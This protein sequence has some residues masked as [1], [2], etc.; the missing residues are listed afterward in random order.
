MLKNNKVISVVSIIAYLSLFPILYDLFAGLAGAFAIIPVILVAISFG[1]KGGIIIGILV[2]PINT[3]LFNLVGLS[4]LNVVAKESGMLPTLSTA[5]IGGIIGYISELKQDLENELNKKKAIGKKL[6]TSEKQFR[7]TINSMEDILITFDHDLVCTSLFVPEK[8]KDYFKEEEFI[9]NHI[10]KIAIIKQLFKEKE[11]LS[12]KKKIMKSLEGEKNYQELHLKTKDFEI[13]FHSSFTPLK[14]GNKII[15]VVSVWRD[16]TR[17]KKLQKKLEERA[18]R[19]TMLDVLN[20]HTGLEYLKEQVSLV[21]KFD[22][23]LTIAFIDIDNLKKTNDN[24]GHKEGDKL[25]KIV[26]QTLK[27]NIRSQETIVRFGGDEFLVI[28]PKT[29]LKKIEKCKKIINLAFA[30]L[31]SKQLKPYNI[32][33]SIGLAQYT[34]DMEIGLKELI[35]LA[36]KRMYQEKKENR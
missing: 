3:L 35:S 33:V 10:T 16:I 11:L 1:I 34:S 18:T 2:Y 6:K 29:T 19:D 21:N 13:F 22:H 26:A 27:E 36:D 31:N 4:G 17:L 9:D 30:K 12:Y 8:W 25:I 15:G 24:Y 5:V 28:F 7:T 23:K 14:E 20:R 32:S